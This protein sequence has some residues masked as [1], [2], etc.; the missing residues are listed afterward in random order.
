MGQQTSK[1]GFV[2]HVLMGL[3]T[4]MRVTL[5]AGE[6]VKTHVVPGRFARQMQTVPLDTVLNLMS[7]MQGYVLPVITSCVTGMS[8]MWIVTVHVPRSAD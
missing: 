5:T 7:I 1:V 3:K 8:P 4:E 2:A 6:R